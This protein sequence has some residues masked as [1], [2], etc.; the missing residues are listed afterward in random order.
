MTDFPPDPTDPRNRW[1]TICDTD[2]YLV[3]PKQS[4]D[5]VQDAIDQGNKI[6]IQVAYLRPGMDDEHYMEG[7]LTVDPNH[8][9]GRT[10]TKA[11]VK[12]G[13]MPWPKADGG[14]P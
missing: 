5:E 10:T 9:C 1:I 14:T 11:R 2:Y 12:T 4:E 3:D 7:M 6:T 13:K 8:P